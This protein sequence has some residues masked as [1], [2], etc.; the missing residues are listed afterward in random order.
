MKRGRDY[1]VCGEDYYAEKGKQYFLTYNIEAIRKNINWEK[2][3]EILGKKMGV[4]KNIL[5]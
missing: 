5:F 2:G 3:T 1:D 4:G